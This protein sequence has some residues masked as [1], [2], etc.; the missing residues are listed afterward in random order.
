MSEPAKQAVEVKFHEDAEMTELTFTLPK[1]TAIKA[2]FSPES[3]TSRVRKVFK[4]EIQTGDGIFDDEVNIR[5]DTTDAT[6]ALLE[7]VDV[8]APIE[9]LILGGGL[10]E[11]DGTHVRIELPGK[12]K[13]DDEL[14]R[15]VVTALGG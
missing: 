7:N 6:V 13:A 1:A 14:A 8:R 15:N 2:S 5:T 4:K 12:R 9:S 11:I 10:L 3:L